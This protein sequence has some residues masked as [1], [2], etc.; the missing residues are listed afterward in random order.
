MPDFTN[1]ILQFVKSNLQIMNPTSPFPTTGYYGPKYFCN[2]K[3]ETQNILSMLTGGESSLLLGFRR[4]GKT[5]L[6]RH[7]MGKITQSLDRN[8]P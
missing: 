6:I 3:I 1:C 4:L 8:L 5:A 2:R 7:V